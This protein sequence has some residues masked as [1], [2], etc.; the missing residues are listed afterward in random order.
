MSDKDLYKKIARGLYNP[1]EHL[2]REARGFINRM[3]VVEP[4]RRATAFQL[5][6]DPWIKNVKLNEVTGNH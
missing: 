2:S 3:L 1:P 4:M 5:L 6:E